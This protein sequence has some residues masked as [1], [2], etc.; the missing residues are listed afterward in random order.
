MF[1]LSTPIYSFPG[2]FYAKYDPRKVAGK[3]NKNQIKREKRAFAALKSG[4][5]SM[6]HSMISMKQIVMHT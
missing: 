5:A 1:L 4:S 6:S 3:P 2:A